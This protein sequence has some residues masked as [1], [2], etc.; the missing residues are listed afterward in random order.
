L[1]LDNNGFAGIVKAP[2]ARDTMRT[3]GLLGGMSW[4]STQ[5]YYR[6]LNQEAARRLGGLHSARL[7]IHSVD[8]ADLAP[9][10]EK[11]CW[12]DIGVHLGTAAQGLVRAGAQGICICTNTM[13]LVADQVERMAG[14]PLIDLLDATAAEARA[15]DM[16]RVGLL[17]TRFTM[18][19]GFYADG[20]ARH[21]LETL[22]PG[23]EDRDVVHRA[24]FEELCLGRFLDETRD[25]FARIMSRLAGLGAQGIVLGCTEIPLLVGPEQSPVPLLDTTKLHALAAMD[26]ALEE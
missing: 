8:F 16:R 19:H 24:I 15:L 4:E 13:H 10:M 17:G 25:A 14:S 21:G 1:F 18:E 9:L 6:I 2:E 3:L 5:A 12:E 26:W 23:P 7:L 11:G 20:L 22:V